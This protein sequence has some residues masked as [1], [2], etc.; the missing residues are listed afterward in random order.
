MEITK[1]MLE[2]RI[3]SVHETGAKAA[4]IVQQAIGADLT[5][6]EILATLELKEQEK[7]DA[8]E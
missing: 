6:R 2:G 8:E 5:L 3:E 1:E 4:A 7:D